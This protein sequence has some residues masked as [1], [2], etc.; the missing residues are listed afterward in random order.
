V[1]GRY[2]ATQR[3]LYEVVLAAQRTTVASVRPGVRYR[4]LHLLAAR[5][6]AIAAS[7]LGSIAILVLRVADV[8]AVLDGP[9][10]L[11]AYPALVGLALIGTAVGLAIAVWLFEAFAPRRARSCAAVGGDRGRCLHCRAGRGPAAGCDAHG[12]SRGDLILSRAA[13]TSISPAWLASR[14]GLV[15][16]R[17]PELRSFRRA[18]LRLPARRGCRRG[19]DAGI[20]RQVRRGVGRTCGAGG[21]PHARPE[22]V[23]QLL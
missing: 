18:S 12:R 14:C 4:D 15:C 20:A 23:F 16:C 21:G 8:G 17:Y 13:V 9:G 11:L 6:L 19:R 1:S 10:W 7:S 22:P 2:S 3:D 5:T